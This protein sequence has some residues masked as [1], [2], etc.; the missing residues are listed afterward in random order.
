MLV[1]LMGNCITIVLSHQNIHFH[2]DHHEI[3]RIYDSSISVEQIDSAVSQICGTTSGRIA[4]QHFMPVLEE[5]ERRTGILSGAT[6][7]NRGKD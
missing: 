4:R 6:E 3:A 2:Q 7:Y 5:L 1:P